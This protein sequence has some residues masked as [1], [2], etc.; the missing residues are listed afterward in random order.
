MTHFTRR[1]ALGAAGAMIAAPLVPTRA[2]AQAFPSK[3][4]RILVGYAPGGYVDVMARAYGEAIQ[5]ATG[6]AVIVDNKPGAAGALAVNE[7]K[8]SAPDGHTIMMLAN[9]AMTVNRVLYKD[10]GYDP[11]KD[12][13]FIS[14][15]PNSPVVAFVRTDLGVRNMQELIEYARKNPMTSGTSG[16]GGM[17]HISV[18]ELNKNFNLKIEPVHYRGEALA[19]QALHTGELK[20]MVGTWAGA[21]LPL[22]A[23]TA[24]A[25]AVTGR[26]RARQL[27]SIPTFAEQGVTSEAFRLTSYM[28]IVGPAGIPDATAK[29]LSDLW[30][31]AG[32]SE[33]VRKFM[34]MYAIDDPARD[35]AAL[36]EI[37]ETEGPT[38]VKV[39]R[40]LGLTPQ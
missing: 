19:M 39:A 13:T 1:Q 18:V 12:F 8:R 5:K 35:R 24:K 6:Q 17:S 10:L 3:T 28:A 37:Y 38:W 4:I 16:V 36:H 11:D 34:E 30:V 27:P 15:I 21:Q 2:A 40:N 31:Q 25:L 33:K 14:Y 9:S 7:M 20:M 22:G 26:Q 32:A 29:R 23:G